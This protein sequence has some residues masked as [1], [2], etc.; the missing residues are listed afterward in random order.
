MRKTL[1]LLLV[2]ALVLTSCGRIR[3]SR[4]NPFNW[5]GRAEAR[6]L[7]G[8][9]SNPLIPRRSA[10]AAREVPDTR[11][12][13]GSVTNLVVERLP[14]GAIIRATAVSARGPM[15]SPCAPSKATRRPRVWCNMNSLPISP[16]PR[17]GPRP[18]AA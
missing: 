10:L 4:I 12:R 1:P 6:Q 5:F 15:R 3:D 8:S 14:G 18:R 11:T 17:R 2:A 13:V 9:E 7:D 16:W